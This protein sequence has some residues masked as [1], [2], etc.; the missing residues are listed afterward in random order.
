MTT[1]TRRTYRTWSS[2]ERR[3]RSVQLADE[4]RE[5]SGGMSAIHF[6]ESECDPFSGELVELT[7]EVNSAHDEWT[8]YRVLYLA[9]TDMT[10]CSCQAALNFAPCWHAGQALMYAR[11]AAEAYSPAGRS[12]AER[13]AYLAWINEPP[14]AAL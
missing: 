6:V 1:T 2:D 14:S 12:E 9:A 3:E 13:D 4:R 11:Y 8:R 5:K 7:V 10:T